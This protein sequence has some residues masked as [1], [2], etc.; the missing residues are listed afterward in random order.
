MLSLSLIIVVLNP[1]FYDMLGMLG[2]HS[3][4][5]PA[6]GNVG[7]NHIRI[8]SY[9]LGENDAY[10]WTYRRVFRAPL[11]ERWS[12]CGKLG[13]EILRSVPSLYS[14]THKDSSLQLH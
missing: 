5:N 13:Q 10:S 7:K 6:Q 11:L 2:V 14:V 12:K 4:H 8:L 3:G 9:S 1:I